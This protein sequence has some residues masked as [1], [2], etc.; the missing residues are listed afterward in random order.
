[1]PTPSKE[2]GNDVNRQEWAIKRQDRNTAHSAR[3]PNLQVL[4]ICFPPGEKHWH[5]ASP[6]PGLTP[7]AIQ[8]PLDG[9][10]VDWLEQVS[11]AQYRA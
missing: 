11:D 5:G 6:T 1:M 10:T 7:I 9:R 8:E 3:H 4:G 2:D